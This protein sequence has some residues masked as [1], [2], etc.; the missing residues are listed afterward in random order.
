MTVYEQVQ[1]AV[2]YIE[3]NLCSPLCSCNAAAARA[4][5]SVRSFN[6]YFWAVTGFTFKAYLIKRRLTECL[7]A[8]G[9][10]RERIIDIALRSGYESHEAFSRAFKKEYGLTPIRCRTDRRMLDGLLKIRLFEEM[11]MGVVEKKLPGM[12]VLCFDGFAPD[13]E[14]K[15]HAALEQWL[16]TSGYRKPYRVFGHNIDANGR[17]SHE[18]KNVGYRFL[19]TVEPERL[20]A[21]DRTNVHSVAAGRF[22]VTGIEGDVTSGDGSWIGA[23]WQRLNEMVAK[24]GY[25]CRPRPRW[26]E[27]ELEPSK[28]G[29]LRLD[30]YLEIE[31]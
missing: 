11:Y 5:M 2:D 23:G 31:P 1:K 26:F 7:P 3:N 12:D 18:P 16:K 28:P 22:V 6:D 15:A 4:H 24:K 21:Q 9:E 13:P 10:G 8:I 30:L 17:L 14:S 29:H 27:E 25:R 19:I 20:T